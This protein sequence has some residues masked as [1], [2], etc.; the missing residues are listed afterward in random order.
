M[1][2]DGACIYIMTFCVA[3]YFCLRETLF[4]YYQWKEI[5]F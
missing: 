2:G 3:G 4:T 5:K 1:L